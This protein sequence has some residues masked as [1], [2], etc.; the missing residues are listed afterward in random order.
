MSAGISRRTCIRLKVSYTSVLDPALRRV[1]IFSDFS[2]MTKNTPRGGYGRRP[3]A[4]QSIHGIVAAH[5]QHIT[6]P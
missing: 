4:G 3:G 1:S 6:D 5:L 2:D